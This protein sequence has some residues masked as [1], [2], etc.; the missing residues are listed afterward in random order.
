[1]VI[2]TDGNDVTLTPIIVPPHFTSI[3]RLANGDM[4]LQGTATPGKTVKIEATADLSTFLLI[5]TTAA[6]F[7]GLFQ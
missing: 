4:A 2:R 7:T 6:D 1:M 3:E 5:G